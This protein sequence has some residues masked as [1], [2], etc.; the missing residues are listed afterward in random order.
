MNLNMGYD[1]LFNSLKPGDTHIYTIVL[2]VRLVI[3]TL[4]DGLV[5][6]Y[7]FII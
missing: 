4:D 7:W 3:I 2:P 1:V 5:P 6:V